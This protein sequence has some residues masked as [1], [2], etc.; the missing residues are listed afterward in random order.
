MSVGG[1]RSD[2]EQRQQQ[3]AQE[4][5]HDVEVESATEKKKESRAEVEGVLSPRFEATGMQEE[6]GEDTWDE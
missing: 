5:Y 1:I 4:K 2:S 6:R 3:L